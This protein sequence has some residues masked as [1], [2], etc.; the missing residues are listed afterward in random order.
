[1]QKDLLHIKVIRQILSQISLGIYRPGQRLP[2]ERQLCEQFEVSRVTLRRALNDLR[3]M[4]VLDIRP[5]S[6]AYVRQ[7]PQ[8]GISHPSLPKDIATITVREVLRAR[9]AIELAA[10]ELAAERIRKPELDILADCIEKMNAHIGNMPEYL[11]NDMAFHNQII[12]SSRNPAL[13]AAFEAIADYHRYSQIFSGSSDRSE[14]DA[15]KHHRNVLAA[16][17]AGDPKKSVRALQR[18]FDSMLKKETYD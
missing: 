4:G 12:K 17:L 15:I 14:A 16:L 7:I 1:M 8:S 5:Q 11:R 10:V 9:K 2:A 13:I 6:G 3:K 18:H